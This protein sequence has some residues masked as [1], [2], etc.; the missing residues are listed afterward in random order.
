MHRDLSL[1]ELRALQRKYRRTT[2]ISDAVSIGDHAAAKKLLDAGVDPKKDP[3]AD[4][5]IPRLKSWASGL[6]MM[7]TTSTTIRVRMA[8][9]DPRRLKR[10]MHTALLVLLYARR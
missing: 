10:R 5:L 4:W 8:K 7:K 9:P 3:N 2:R 1:K 6:S